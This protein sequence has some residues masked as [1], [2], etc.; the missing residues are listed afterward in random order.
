MALPVAL[1]LYSIRDEMAKDMRE[2]LIKVMSMGYDGVEFAGLYGHS[3]SE[4]KALCAELGL[5][6]ISAHVPI[7]DM[8][9]DPEGVV[10]TYA[11][12]G[13]KYIVVPYVIEERRPGGSKFDQT[14]E[15][16]KMIG[17][18]AKKHGM[19]LLYHNHDFEFVKIDGK[20][21]LDLIYERVPASLLETEIDTCWA[22]VGGENPSKYVL[23]ATP[24][25][26]RLSTSR[27]SR[28][29]SPRICMSSSASTRRSSIPTPSSSDR[30]A[31]AIRTSRTFS[32]LPRR[33][34]P[35]GSSSSRISRLWA[36]LRLSA[37]R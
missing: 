34:A 21:G 3:A 5:N 9:K 15:D 11:E 26:R 37:R 18:I 25:A 6:P 36:R 24:D 35:A 4:I 32:P 30:S 27:I 19:T 13:C 12:I 14:I 10:S 8:V 7:D 1:Q 31:S 20:Y 28:A 16:M 22:N 17:E 23:Q 2:A 29:A 33:R